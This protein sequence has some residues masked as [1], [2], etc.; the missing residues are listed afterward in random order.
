MVKIKIVAIAALTL[1]V[2]AFVLSLL[3]F[4][5]FLGAWLGL[6][7]LILSFFALKWYR[8]QNL[9]EKRVKKALN[10]E[11]PDRIPGK[12]TVIELHFSGSKNVTCCYCLD[13]RILLL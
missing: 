7:A 10:H 6:F 4:V 1:G 13:T 12:Q 5:Q 3:P 9:P 8:E 11:K 2:L